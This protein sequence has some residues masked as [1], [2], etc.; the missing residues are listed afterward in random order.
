MGGQNQQSNRSSYG[1]GCSCRDAQALS[2]RSQASGTGAEYEELGS[3]FRG[4]LPKVLV[5]T[6][7]VR[8]RNAY[9]R[10]P[11]FIAIIL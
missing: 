10:T 1:P 7:R 9:G 11:L 2:D 6:G 8:D 4:V 5:L 3:K